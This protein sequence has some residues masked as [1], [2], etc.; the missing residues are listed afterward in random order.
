MYL[1]YNAFISYEVF[2][3]NTDKI[4][5]VIIDMK[6]NTIEI[7]T[8][9]SLASLIVASH[10]IPDAVEDS[11]PIDPQRS[12]PSLS[13]LPNYFRSKFRITFVLKSLNI[14]FFCYNNVLLFLCSALLPF[15]SADFL[16]I[17]RKEDIFNVTFL[18]DS[19]YSLHA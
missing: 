6:I 16:P 18:C 17:T 10:G 2:F 13:S 9:S 5:G 8:R 4:W 12:S 19:E 15:S 14:F 1:Q 11:W 7:T 3:Y